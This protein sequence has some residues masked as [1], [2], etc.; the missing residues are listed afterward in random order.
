[1]T[2][3]APVLHLLAGPNGA[4]KSTYYRLVLSGLRLPWVNAD[5]IAADTWPDDPLSHGHDASHAAAARR[6][7]LLEQRRSFVTE[8]VF[9]HE[10]KV[11]LVR[12]AA[13]MGYLVHLHILVVPVELSLLR[14]RLRVADGGHD[15]PADKIRARHARL[16]PLV[17]A[18]VDDSYQATV[19]DSRHTTFPRLATFRYGHR[20]WVDDDTDTSW[21]PTALHGAIAPT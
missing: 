14:V 4:G 18:A 6:T 13:A 2:Q 19:I 1:M 10:S 16:W 21:L 7:D 17:I 20:T 3:P 5:E 12:S 9:S 15:V 11:E 8:T